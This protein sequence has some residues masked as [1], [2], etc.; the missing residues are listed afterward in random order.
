MF[1]E[2]ML[3]L[4]TAGA[5][6]ASYTDIK[7]GLI[8]N[9]LTFPLMLSGLAGYFIYSLYYKNISIF[10]TTIMAFIV[11]FILSYLLWTLGVFSAGDAKEFMF[12]SALVPVYPDFLGFSPAMPFY[13]F[14]VAFLINTFLVIFP[15]IFIYG[16]FLTLRLGK[17]SELNLNFKK[18][19]FGALVI[20]ISY[21][22]S[23]LTTPL[24]FPVSFIAIYLIKSRWLR[25]IL[26]TSILSS[27][28]LLNPNIDAIKTIVIRY[29]FISIIFIISGVIMAL[30]S[31][32][33]KYGLVREIKISELEEGMIAAEEIYIRSDKVIKEE[34]DYIGKALKLLR[35]TR[36]GEVQVVT[37]KASGVSKKEIEKLKELVEKNRTEDSIK[38][39]RRMPFAPVILA[40]FIISLIYGDI[41]LLLRQ[42]VG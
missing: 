4:A 15:A 27:Y 21:L 16:V 25:V 26:I 24:A 1:N 23:E 8:P 3:I 39:K 11:V 2:A 36:G 35:G 17:L 14:P 42:M 19:F 32:L 20:I 38:I 13:P 9:R 7:Y 41:S 12:L 10:I 28:V 34:P 18:S 30:V 31:V 37:T 29:V 6:I 33:R 22:L 5:I 40:G